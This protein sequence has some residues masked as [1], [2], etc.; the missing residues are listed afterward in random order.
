MKKLILCSSHVADI[1]DNIFDAWEQALDTA[2]I[3]EEEI[4]LLDYNSIAS[5][6]KILERKL[7]GQ[8]VDLSFTSL[9]LP[10]EGNGLAI[11]G[12]KVGGN[13]GGI[14]NSLIRGVIR[15][16]WEP[17]DPDENPIEAIDDA[18]S[19]YIQDKYGYCSPASAE[20]A[21]SLVSQGNRTQ[22]SGY[23]SQQYMD[24]T[25][26]HVYRDYFGNI[27]LNRSALRY[28]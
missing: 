19:V 11:Q 5:F 26:V 27:K 3:A 23:G 10:E 20:E 13:K 2:G 1:S 15:S 4:H 17:I 22:H 8:G 25:N 12:L 7:D 9:V 14:A 28:D 16:A 21:A 18:N 6:E 24:I